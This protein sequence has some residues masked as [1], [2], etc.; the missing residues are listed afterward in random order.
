[1]ATSATVLDVT[2]PLT[3]GRYTISDFHSAGRP[4]SVE[5]VFTHSSNVGAGMLALSAGAARFGGFLK[6]LGL[7]D[8]MTTEI[9]PVGLPQLPERM[10][11]VELITMSYGHGIAVAPLQFASAAASILN[12]GKKVTPT[13]LRYRD[14]SAKPVAV[15]SELTSREIARLFRL[16]VLDPSGTG[17]RAEVPGYRVGGKTGTAERAD[18]GRYHEK[19]VLSSFLGA[20]PMDAPQYVTYVVLFEPEAT[21]ETNNQRTASMNAAPVTGR[22]IRRIAPQLGVMPLMATMTQ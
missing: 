14:D 7:T 8:P 5:E 4:L 16:N 10:E 11:R 19:A 20:F 6:R 9:G 21:A 17:K 15:T 1:L 3:A 2:Q 12:G 13:F 18:N 22:L